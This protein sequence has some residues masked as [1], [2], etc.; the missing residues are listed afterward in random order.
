VTDGRT[1]GQTDTVRQ[2]RPRL[3]TASRGKKIISL[4][5]FLFRKINDELKCTTKNGADYAVARCPSVR[6]PSVTRRCSVYTVIHTLN[7]FSPSGSPII[8][9]FPHQTGWQYSDRDPLTGAS[10]AMG[11]EKNHDSRPIYHFVSQTMQD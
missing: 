8:L 11:Y 10:N 5:L 2:H 4:N 6:L 1:D 7:S 9:V 3:C